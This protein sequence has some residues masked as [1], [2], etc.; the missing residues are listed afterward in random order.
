MTVQ[1]VSKAAHRYATAFFELLTESNSMEEARTELQILV[2]CIKTNDDLKKSLHSPICSREQ[3]ATILADLSSKL[4]FSKLLSNFLGI[5]AV[6]GRSRDIVAIHLAFEQIYAK[7]QGLSQ[8]VVTTAQ[9]MNE[10]QR[11]DIRKIVQS[12]TGDDFVLT[13]QVEPELIGGIQIQ[14]G[15][16]LYDAS[17]ASKLDRLNNS[18]KGV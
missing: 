9:P 5:I 8:V 15:S 2:D 7:K 11:E 13:E 3:K 18:M 1:T 6:N 12:K 14:I 4:K 10:Q 16:T 17:I